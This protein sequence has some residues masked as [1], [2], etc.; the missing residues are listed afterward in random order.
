[1][2]LIVHDIFMVWECI[3]GLKLTYKNKG[4]KFKIR[5]WGILMSGFKVDNDIDMMSS[6]DL[7]PKNVDVLS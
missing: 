5:N 6:G 4:K 2:S 7:K 1:M 3:T